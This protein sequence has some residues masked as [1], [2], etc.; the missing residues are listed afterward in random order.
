MMLVIKAFYKFNK[1][2]I[3]GRKELQMKH[4]KGHK[5]H[6]NFR[7]LKLVKTTPRIAETVGSCFSE[8]IIDAWYLLELPGKL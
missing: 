8:C 6:P 4:I 3:E 5:R 7:Y 1:S 2:S